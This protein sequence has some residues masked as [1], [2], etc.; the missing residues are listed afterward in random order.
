VTAPFYNRP[1]NEITRGPIK[2][3]LMGKLD[4]GL[5]PSH[6]NHIKI[7]ISR[8][9]AEALDDDAIQANPALGIRLKSKSTKPPIRPLVGDE[10]HAL[11]EAFRNKY[12]RHLALVSLLLTTGMRIGEALG[13]QWG[14]IDFEAGTAHI[15]RNYVRQ[16]IDTPKSGRDRVVDL[17][18]GM[19]AMLRERRRQQSLELLRKGRKIKWVFP[20]RNPD[21][22]L[23]QQPWHE[24]TFY[25]AVKTAGL[26][27]T[28]IHDLRHTYASTMISKGV[29]PMYVS[30][31]LGHA[32]LSITLDIYSRWIP[33]RKDKPVSILSEFV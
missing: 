3:F 12:P 19:V 33:Q 20:S 27:H 24:G 8:V 15:Q 29:N 9:M 10:A 2:R 17:T 5:S 11:L 32:S 25:K 28:R 18:D 6:T 23:N 13:L 1:I 31:Q 16:R 22:P 30:Q 4:S 7:A 21:T 26:R 14:D